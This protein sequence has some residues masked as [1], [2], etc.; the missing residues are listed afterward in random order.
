MSADGRGGAPQPRRSSPADDPYVVPLTLVG[1]GD[2]ARAGGKGA[3]LGELV[4]AGFAVPEGFVVTTRLYH[5]ALRS[6][7]VVR[8]ATTT[9]DEAAHR[10]ETILAM[11]IPAE[12]AA[13]IRTAY[14]QLG[15]GPVAVRS[16]ATAEDLPGAAFA[17]QQE[18]FLNVVGPAAVL[19]AVRGCWA[20]LWAERAVS[21]RDRLGQEAD[22][23]M[24]VVVQ[25]M[26][27]AEFA[28]VLF[29]ANP[30]TGRR[31][32]VVIEASPGLGEAV[33]S[34]VVTPEHVVVDGR[35]RLQERRP[36]RAEVVI[37]S[38]RGG[39]V[40]EDRGPGSDDR[41]SDQVLTELA[42]T[43]VEIGRHFG[44]PED[45]EW[46]RA[47][48]KTWIVQARPLTALPPAPVR[49]NRI[50]RLAGATAAELVPTRPYP[51]DLTAW[52]V[53]G[54]FAILDR[55]AA[56][57]LGIGID[58]PAMFPEADGV[59]TQ[60]LPPRAHPTRRILSTPARLRRRLRRY[61]PARWTA[62]P[63]FAAYERALDRLHAQQPCSMSWAE[64]TAVPGDVLALLD[65]F[66]DLRIDYLPGAAARLARLRVLLGAVGQVGEFWPLLAGQ[67][68]RTRAAN[69]ALQEIADQIRRTP[70]WA[71]A[72]TTR[73]GDDL[74]AAV[75]ESPDLVPLQQALTAWLH[76]Y[77]HRE[78]TSAALISAPT[79]A[80][81]PQLLLSTVGGLVAH[82]AAAPEGA[83]EGAAAAEVRIR[84]SR[85]VRLTRTAP[86]ISEAAQAARSAMVFREDSHF[87]ALRVRPVLLSALLEAGTRLAHAG[88]LATPR[89][90]FHLRL[91]ELQ[92]LPEPADLAA[93]QRG[94]L[95]SL[96]QQRTARRA[97]FGEAPLIS[98]ATL[99]PRPRRPAPDALVTGAPGGGGT[100]TG[101]VRVI[102][103]PSEFGQLQ[104]GDIL[105][106]P[107]TNPAWTPL[108]QLAAA[109]V[110]DAG[111][112]GSHAAIV[113]RE[114]GI[115]AVMGTGNGTTVLPEGLTVTVDGTRGD[116]VA[117]AGPGG[118]GPPHSGEATRTLT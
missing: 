53:P 77:G 59:V 9:R 17:G 92:A 44:G 47:A 40:S 30:V 114:Y 16:S 29:T 106:C 13:D 93:E 63:R 58:V 54:W 105:V 73:H 56:E 80:D 19:D 8:S 36:G 67:A 23:G 15:E 25:R 31:D 104:A 45:V 1:R 94:R 74:V 28:G 27:D 10:R 50:R 109:V 115:P 113:A 7:G 90:V 83:G 69:D 70:A 2:A 24:A 78:T 62:D 85:R 39:G 72:F 82:S 52:T 68:T 101:P 81:D 38:Q 79:W 86:R 76:A 116:V 99:H 41:L 112:F 108:F 117:A 4:R 37:R 65:A 107:Y 118:V 64:L 89:E 88:V 6:A 26:V 98:P 96:V 75:W 71:E 21:Y 55:M 87:H 12:L 51:L 102:R 43:G 11:S 18:T 42:R 34:G 48:G 60:V 100:A 20:S 84:H 95:Q 49:V 66:V 33:V 111:S 97:A 46:A 91:A 22:P 3:N 110:A 14:R 61:D 32:E 5:E 35:G 103:G 57:M